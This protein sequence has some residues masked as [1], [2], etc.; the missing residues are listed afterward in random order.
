MLKRLTM[1]V[2]AVFLAAGLGAGTAEARPDGQWAQYSKAE[3]G[4]MKPVVRHQRQK[5]KKMLKHRREK[6]KQ[7]IKRQRSV[8]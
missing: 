2:L 4:N 7:L 6:A 8:Q 5:A 1:P 3:L